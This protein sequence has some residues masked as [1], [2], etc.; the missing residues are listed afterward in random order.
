MSVLALLFLLLLLPACE[1]PWTETF[2]SDQARLLTDA[3]SN[4]I[5]AYHEKLLEDLDIHFCVVILKETPALI[6]EKADELFKSY[7]LGSKTRG[8][9]GL[10][11]IIDPQGRQTRIET[12]YGLEPMFPDAFVSYIQNQQMAPFYKAGRV[13][14]GIE[15]TVEL[16]VA[17]A[18][19]AIDAN[20]YDPAEIHERLPQYS[21]GAGA[22]ALL[23]ES[24]TQTMPAVAS[25]DYGP[26]PSADAAFSEYL[27]VLENRVRN[28]SLGL[29]SE[30][31]QTLL[32]TRLITEAQQGNELSEI[33]AV[34]ETRSVKERGDFAVIQFSG[35]RRVPP[36][37]FRKRGDAWT[38]DLSA[39][40][41]LI[42]FDH[43]NQWCIRDKNSEFSFAF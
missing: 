28:P 27:L 38:I 30:E 36:Y 40:S 24:N 5:K 22:N 18:M 39:A 12:G 13:P 33:R 25:G 23:A 11:L 1:L 34:Y 2:L 42:G 29:Y 16:L 4:R 17:Q 6:E 31:T 41:R 20:D 10:L 19:K 15:A 7:S 43:L 37:F 35:S 3:Q 26:Q 14:E 8:A 32:R 21:G 9:K